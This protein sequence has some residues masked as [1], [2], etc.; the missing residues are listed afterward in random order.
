MTESGEEGAGLAAIERAHTLVHA[1][2][3]R[4]RLTDLGRTGLEGVESRYFRLF[5]PVRYERLRLPTSLPEF[6]GVRHSATL[7]DSPVT[8][9]AKLGGHWSEHNLAA[10]C[11][12]AAC[13][14]RCSYCYVDYRH[15]AG[16]DSRA[17]TAAGL[18]GEFGRMRRRLASG[19]RRLS[20]LRLSGGE[21]LLAPGLITEVYRELERLDLLGSVVVKA[22]SNLSALPYAL[23]SLDDS[24]RRAFRDVAP[25][26]TLHATLHARPGQRD[27]RAILEG[28]ALAVDLG[29][30]VYPAIGGADWPRS[31]MLALLDALAGASAGLVHRLA[32]RPFNLA[33]AERYGRR[34]TLKPSADRPPHLSTSA[35]WEELLRERTGEPYLARP[36]HEIG[37]S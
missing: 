4:Y 25:R 23:R 8:T 30:D 11:H 5:I 21:P 35:V 24:G 18:V 27:W 29:I 26:L 3:G 28:L 17:E 19:G 9:A 16:D 1:S 34:K 15:L 13:N 22:E 36:R 14:F 7:S 33:Y 37:L 20:I 12:V 31:D 6:S 10:I 2:P 32:V